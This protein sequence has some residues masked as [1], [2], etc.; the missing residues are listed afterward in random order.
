MRISV[1]L[2]ACCALANQQALAQSTPILIFGGRD[3]SQFLG[4]ISCDKLEANSVW[5]ELSQYGWYNSIGVWSSIQPLKSSMSEYS[6]CSQFST[7][8]P[9]LVDHSGNFYGY[10]SVNQ[11]MTNSVC[12]FTGNQNA[13]LALQV[14][15]G[16]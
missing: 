15:C 13:C 7:E 10:L 14:M 4:C 9:V 12:A 2:F 8:P 1:I 3:H 16:S 6:A 11:F 5:N